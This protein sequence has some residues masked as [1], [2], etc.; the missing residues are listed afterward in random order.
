LINCLSKQ[1]TRRLSKVLLELRHVNIVDEEDLGGV[2]HF[3]CEHSSSLLVQI[4]LEGILQILAC[5]LAREVDEGRVKLLI[6]IHQEVLDD[7]GLANSSLTCEQRIEAV[8]HQCLQ[9]VFI[10]DGVVSWHQD[11]EEISLRVVL[12]VRNLFV[13]RLQAVIIM[14]QAELKDITVRELGEVLSD[15]P[16]E[17]FAENRS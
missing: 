10:L 3:R 15:L 9:D 8:V 17:E 7:D 11:V 5:G 16:L 12:E 1:L 14:I 2:R 6:R 13:K 4:T